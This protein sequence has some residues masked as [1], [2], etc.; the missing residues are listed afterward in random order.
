[1]FSASK[2]LSKHLGLGLKTR[3]VT[4]CGS[5]EWQIDEHEA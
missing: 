1:M 5:D 2:N 3:T 4:V